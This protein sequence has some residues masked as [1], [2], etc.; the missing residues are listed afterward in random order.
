M[1]HGLHQVDPLVGIPVEKPAD[2][3]DRVGRRTAAP[4]VRVQ[5]TPETAK[6]ATVSTVILLL[7]F[8]SLHCIEVERET[9]RKPGHVFLI[10]LKIGVA[11]WRKVKLRHLFSFNISKRST[12]CHPSSSQCHSEKNMFLRYNYF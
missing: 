8:S 9:W 1:T 5:G 3:I 7:I 6:E 2:E 4:H 12:S 10:P 11:E